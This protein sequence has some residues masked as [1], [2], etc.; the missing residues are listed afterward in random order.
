MNKVMKYL[1]PL[2]ILLAMVLAQSLTHSIFTNKIASIINNLI[3]IVGLFVFGMFLS[4]RKKHNRAWGKKVI[5]SLVM[6][7]IILVKVDMIQMKAFGHI[8]DTLFR[9][10]ALLYSIIIYCGWAFFE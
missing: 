1:N 3:I 8:V 5:I 7:I 9:N 2:L 10:N 6:F 4:Y